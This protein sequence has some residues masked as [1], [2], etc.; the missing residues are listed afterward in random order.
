MRSLSRKTLLLMTLTVLAVPLAMGATISGMVKGTDG[1]PF[2]GAFV[3]A[4]HMTTGISTDVLSQE[5]GSYT[6]P[7]LPPGTY[8]LT[9][10]AVGYKADPQSETLQDGR[11]TC[12]RRFFLAKGESAVE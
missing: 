8:Q 5:D 12:Q 6:V 3:E 4:R 11:S 10:R 2:E 7:N 9:I 1:A